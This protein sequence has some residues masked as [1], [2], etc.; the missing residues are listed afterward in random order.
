[1]PF[2]LYAKQ[3]LMQ[4]IF[5]A[6]GPWGHVSAL[7]TSYPIYGTFSTTHPYST[8]GNVSP[9]PTYASAPGLLANTTNWTVTII[10][11][12]VTV[13]NATALTF[14][15]PTSNWWNAG[16]QVWLLLFYYTSSAQPIAVLNIPGPYPAMNSSFQA[17][18]PAGSIVVNWNDGN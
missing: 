18:F 11:N 2:T 12:T 15:V 7:G 4:S 1:M 8:F 17:V 16:T 6:G 13:T 10:N 9:I 14:P 3:A 5:Q